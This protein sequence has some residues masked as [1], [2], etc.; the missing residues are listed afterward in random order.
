MWE[1]SQRCPAEHS[2]A[3]PTL[4]VRW[5]TAAGLSRLLQ[6]ALIC[7]HLKLFVL[8]TFAVVNSAFVCST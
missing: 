8:Q 7:H 3:V 1:P 4:T 5:R 2:A 6:S